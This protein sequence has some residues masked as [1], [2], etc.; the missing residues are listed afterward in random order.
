MGT[1]AIEFTFAGQVSSD[2]VM[3]EEDVQEILG[4]LSM[5]AIERSFRNESD[6]SMKFFIEFLPL[7]GETLTEAVVRVFLLIRDALGINSIV[8]AFFRH[9]TETSVFY[10]S[11][12]MSMETYL[13]RRYFK[14][15]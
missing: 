11:E 8:G 1:G 4:R 14:Y 2:Y 15:M 9:V 10:Q 3:P 7:N 13:F 12:W 6:N 5:P